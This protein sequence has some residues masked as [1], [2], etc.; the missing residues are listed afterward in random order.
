MAFFS[1]WCVPGNQISK[2]RF[3]TQIFLN[4]FQVCTCRNTQNKFKK[5]H[6][7]S[8]QIRGREPHRYSD[9]IRGRERAHRERTSP[10]NLTSAAWGSRQPASRAARG[11]H[12]PA[13]RA[14]RVSHPTRGSREPGSLVSFWSC[15][16]RLGLQS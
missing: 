7:Y 12:W 6:C 14:A 16:A 8:D 2:T 3:S 1:T 9:Q 4:K 13:S 11:S 10:L 5:P 15:R